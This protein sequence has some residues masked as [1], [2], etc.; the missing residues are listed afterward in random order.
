MKNE[1]YT[2]QE[3]NMRSSFSL[4][5]SLTTNKPS[6]PVTLEEVY[7]LIVSDNTLKENTEKYRYFRSQGFDADADKIKRSK[8]WVFTPAARFEG[9]R[10][11]KNL[12]AYTQYSM[13]DIDKLEDGQAEK[14]IR[15]LKD[16]PYWLLA[17]ITLSG[18]GLRIIYRVEGVTDSQTYLK[19]FYQGNDHYCRLLGITRFDSA[20]KDATR[21]SVL[22]HDPNALFR[23]G[24]ETFP[25][26]Y[27]KVVVAEVWETIELMLER[28]GYAYRDGHHNEYIS[29]AGYL[30]N[31]YGV[32]EDEAVE[33]MQRRFP[34]YDPNRTVSHIHSCYATRT[35]EHGKLHPS[36]RPKTTGKKASKPKGEQPKY[37]SVEEIETTL[38]EL[39][40]FRWN[41]IT[42]MTE[43]CW[44]DREE[45]FRPM[46]D[47]D[48]GTLW[49]RI[50]KQ[51]KPLRMKDMLWV[52]GSEFVPVHHP[53]KD[54]FYGLPAWKEGDADHIAALAGTVMLTDDSIETR[55][56]FHRC[57]KKWLVGMIA[58]FLSD[59]VNHE[60]LV[61]IG[62]Q[63]I[64]K[65]TWFHFL[66]P[67]ELRNYYVAKN[68]SRRM[69]KDDRLLLA[70]AGLIC[71]EE[72]VSMTDEEVDQIKAAVSLPQ[73]VERA[74]YA[75]NKEVRPHLASFCGTGN[76]LN[77]LTDITGNRRWLP[78]EVENILS[79]Y[80]HPLDYTGLYSQVMHLW[81]SGF[82]YWFNQE[83]IRA[84]AKHV[85]RFEAPNMEEDQ[86][87]KHFRIPIPGEPYE[88]YSVADVL[89][90][91]NMEHKMVLSP[92]K[93]GMLLSKMGY[94]KI[95]TSKTRGYMVYRFSPEEIYS[96]RRG[97]AGEG[98]V[99]QLPISYA[100]E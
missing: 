70:E 50:N 40:D 27:D 75:R 41:E 88:I 32:D 57:L 21:G 17:Y 15:L 46:T 67:P 91:I 18:K 54:Y 53:F 63:G 22:C 52:L 45:G 42:R 25:V 77:F 36:S 82:P 83:E 49:S 87:R 24:A 97:K 90:V 28:R 34:D 23:E 9:K 4:F 11:G 12:V 79:P 43:I 20:V 39:A 2:P 86:I 68:N 26:Y 78:F 99:R 7:R 58:G 100:S 16:D 71:L 30:L 81:Q 94:K 31:G 55:G 6:T 74:A 37:I 84:L 98:E 62:K 95:R 3:M 14:L 19:A 35:D 38:A 59:R 80:D 66:L 89:S 56:M 13:V 8:S 44:K 61:L 5:Q 29:K 73:V 65:T 92:T 47:R 10:H 48:E 1:P 96:N 69:N 64:Y 93:V 33:W 76:H 60:I 51:G 72:I 85:S